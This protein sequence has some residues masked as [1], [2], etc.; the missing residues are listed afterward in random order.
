MGVWRRASRLRVRKTSCRCGRGVA[1]SRRR[2]RRRRFAERFSRRGDKVKPPRLALCEA[3]DTLRRRVWGLRMANVK[4]VVRNALLL[5]MS[6]AAP[7]AG[8]LA[9]GAD[10]R[11]IAVEPGEPPSDLGGAEVI[12]AEGAFVAPGFISAHSHLMTSGSRGLA[13]DLALYGWVDAMTQYTRHCD[14]DDIYWCTLHGALDFL[15]NGVTCAY[16]FTDTR[17]PLAMNEKGQRLPAG[18]MKPL[19]YA[20]AQIRAKVDAGL[21]FLNSVPLND[22]EGDAE[23]VLQRFA[24]AKAYGDG[25]TEGGFYLGSAVTGAGQWS[26]NPDVARVEV[27]AMRRFGVVNQPHFLETA[28]EVEYQRSKWSLYRDAGALGPKLIFGH[29]VQATPEMIVEAGRCGCAMSWQPT[30]NGRLASGFANIRACVDAGVR[31]GV[32]LDDQSCTDVADP[33]GNMRFGVYSQRAHAKSPAAMGVAEMLRM[34]TLGSAETL[35]LEADVG[36]LEVGKYADFLIVDPREPDI[37]PVWDAVG[38]YVLACGL[39]N[40][41]AVYVGG[42]LAARDGRLTSPLA[43]EA[44][45]Q[46][47]AR[48]KRIAETHAG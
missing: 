4:R 21:R 35:G 43:G 40:L 19:D 13:M 44:N 1:V 42:E 30:S 22:E 24:D 45:R 33:W 23:A 31:V 25:F 14:A 8:W 5:T 26:T 38:S 46:L 17:L 39:R 10:G 11:L 3:D 7:F 32:G 28:Q 34:H 15:N 41:K 36:S 20:T 9:A 29:F 6:G 48:L 18:P 37:G 27:E 16:D 47:H 2:R 12:D